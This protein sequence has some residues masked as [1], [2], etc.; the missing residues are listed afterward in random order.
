MLNAETLLRRS[1]LV[2]LYAAVVLLVLL[3]PFDFHGVLRPKSELDWTP[4]TNGVS[5]SGVAAL[6]AD[7]GLE[8]LFRSLV[9]GEGLT[10]E[11]WLST[12]SVD[13]LGPA[14][15]VT[16]S[17]DSQ[18]RNFTLGQENGDLVIRVRT[19]T[20]NL[21]GRPNLIVPDV[22]RVSSVQHL[23]VTYDS[24][25]MSV[26]VDGEPRVVSDSLH[27]GLFETWDPSHE[28]LL[29]NE[30]DGERPWAGSLFLVALFNRSLDAQ[31]VRQNFSVGCRIPAVTEGR[32]VEGG[33]ALY[34]FDTGSGNRVFDRG[35]RDERTDLTFYTGEEITRQY[36]LSS[37]LEAA[38]A[39]DVVLNII[40]FLPLG[41]LGILW[42]RSRLSFGIALTLVV[43]AGGALSLIAEVLQYFSIVR[44]SSLSDVISN[45]IGTLAGALAALARSGANAKTSAADSRR[46]IT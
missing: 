20:T 21:N 39:R 33:V 34:R 27:K 25:K 30:A 3:A 37:P 28:F 11:A 19:T 6:R 22:F 41:Y 7:E 40:L 13:Q 38:T 32:V 45:T 17:Q 46:E 4:D 1:H 36:F 23:V 2:L 29:G 12:Q 16:F 43:L 8:P 42:L 14:R 18:H 44:H 24:H 35:S 31:E 5:F 26:Y 15:I 9:S 10:V